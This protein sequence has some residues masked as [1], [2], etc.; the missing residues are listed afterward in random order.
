MRDAPGAMPGRQGAG[1]ILNRQRQK[2]RH[3]VHGTGLVGRL[4]RTRVVG[5][6][7]VGDGDLELGAGSLL[8]RGR[9]FPYVSLDL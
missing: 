7:E 5:W 3:N 1:W 2:R 9:S 6:R 4:H 8:D